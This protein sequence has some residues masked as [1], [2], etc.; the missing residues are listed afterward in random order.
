MTA[1]SFPIV[2]Q[3][4]WGWCHTL[5]WTGFAWHLAFWTLLGGLVVWAVL[6]AGRSRSAPSPNARAT[7]DE[8][9]ARGELTADEYREH[10]EAL[11]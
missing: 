3:T 9:L 6:A 1:I 2:A 5:G 10:R 4:T 8:R 11:R 7:L